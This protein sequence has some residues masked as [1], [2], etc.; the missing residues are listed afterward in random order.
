MNDREAKLAVRDIPQFGSLNDPVS[1]LRL[2]TICANVL[3][4]NFLETI[5][6]VDAFSDAEIL[7]QRHVAHERLAQIRNEVDRYLQRDS[8]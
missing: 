3:L 4:H 5:A 7:R 2:S 6:D 1:N 8:K